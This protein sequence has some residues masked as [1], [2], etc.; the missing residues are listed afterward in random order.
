MKNFEK[1][2]NLRNDRGTWL[3]AAAI[4]SAC[5]LA[6]SAN[7]LSITDSTSAP[8]ANI[9]TSQLTDLGPGTQDN[10]RDYMNNSGP[11]GQTF[12]VAQK[13]TLSSITVLGRGDSAMYYNGGPQPFTAGVVWSIQIS[14]VNVSTGS[15]TP[16]DTE[17]NS[18]YVPT[19]GGASDTAYLTYALANPV[20]L[21]AGQEYAFNLFVNDNGVNVNGNTGAAGQSWFGLAHSAV[22]AYAG[23]TAQNSDTTVA[24]TPPNGAADVYGAFA[25]PN[26]GSYD[27]VFA[28]QG[29][30]TVPEPT[31]LALVG[32]GGLGLAAASRRRR[33]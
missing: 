24:N 3:I 29:T 20:N 21:T 33:A 10:N 11:V 12:S 15:L 18:D 19:G 32:L 17:S 28:A 23:G 1:T 25:A 9:L 14:S 13:S 26:P 27:Y 31:T 16:I 4:L 30:I 6:S 5:A 7:A 8:S 2:N 22:D